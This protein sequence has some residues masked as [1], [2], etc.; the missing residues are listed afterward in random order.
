[1]KVILSLSAVAPSWQVIG[2]GANTKIM[3]LP[4]VRPDIAA[5]F[6][7]AKTAYKEASK[8]HKTK[9]NLEK[10]REAQKAK[11]SDARKTRIATM[12]PEVRR[13]KTAATQ[14]MSAASKA[15]RK[16]FGIKATFGFSAPDL[17]DAKKFA[18]ISVGSTL[19]V[20][21]V[22]KPVTLVRAP[23]QSVFDQ[24]AS[25][26]KTKK[27]KNSTGGTI[28]QARA[29]ADKKKLEGGRKGLYGH[30]LPK[31]GTGS[32][33]EPK[34][35]TV[36][37]N[38]K[39]SKSVPESHMKAINEIAKNVT[40]KNST[41]KASGDKIQ[42]ESKGFKATIKR[43]GEE[44]KLTHSA[45]GAGRGTIRGTLKSLAAKLAKAVKSI[46]AVKGSKLS[47]GNYLKAAK[48]ITANAGK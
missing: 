29:A 34:S 21:G 10:L 45:T 18:K 37:K 15:L 33:G 39:I 12:Q 23:S 28:Q 11:P 24:L 16:V 32:T 5:A 2:K 36:Q 22:A 43:E 20:K 40:G 30:L 1:M 44:Y 7:L 48:G 41:L 17:F 8:Y 9:A 6:K 4:K 31:G 26:T 42:F 25:K 19:K 27:A 47:T 46:E 3:F 14:A 13:C 38:V 35:K